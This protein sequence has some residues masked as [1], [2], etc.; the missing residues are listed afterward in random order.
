MK[1]QVVQHSFS[2]G[3]YSYLYNIPSN[4]IN[5]LNSNAYALNYFICRL[6]ESMHKVELT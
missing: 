1:P 2:F 4:E 5:I 6:R 3:M